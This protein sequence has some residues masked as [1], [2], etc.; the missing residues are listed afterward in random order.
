MPVTASENL[1]TPLKDSALESLAQGNYAQAIA[2]LQQQIEITPNDR[3]SYWYLGLAWFLDGEIDTAS[4]T[5]FSVLYDAPPDQLSLWLDELL[6]ILLTQAEQACQ[7][8]QFEQA[9]RL[10]D[11]I[12][13]TNPAHPQAIQGRQRS[14]RWQ[15]YQQGFLQTQQTPY[16]DYPKHVH[17]ETKALCSAACNFCP[18]PTLERKGTVMPDDLIAKVIDDLTAIPADLPFQLS[19]FKVSEP[20]LEQRLFDILATINAKLPNAQITLTSNASPLTESRLKRLLS[21]QNISYLWIS[22]NDH[23]R[24]AYEA[25]MS[26]S[27]EHTLDRLRMLHQYKA[28]GKLP[29]PVILSRVGDGTPVDHEF[30]QWVYDHFPHFKLS[31]FQ[32]G[33]WLGQVDTPIGPVP[34]VGCER[35]FDLSITATGKVAHCCMDG[36]AAWPIGDVRT[37]HVL[38]IYNAPA[39]RS[40]RESTLTRLD[41]EPCRRCTFL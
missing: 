24:D 25:T 19:P 14:Q 38:E 3:E 26:L 30:M 23:R 15:Q 9:I 33:G 11:Q 1:S 27:Y 37:Q 7:A 36:Q 39:Y 20:F 8:G 22:F 21:I 12:L 6:T 29:F 17:L 2:Q 16:L 13:E 41:A 18:Y 40:L 35:W 32:R 10:Y 4:S 5:W 34:N 31:V 28:D